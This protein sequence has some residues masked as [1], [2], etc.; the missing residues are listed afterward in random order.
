[1]HVEPAQRMRRVLTRTPDVLGLGRVPDR[2]LQVDFKLGISLE[3]ALV[4]VGDV[5]I[6]DVQPRWSRAPGVHG[7]TAAAATSSTSTAAVDL[8][9]VVAGFFYLHEADLESSSALIRAARSAL[10]DADR[11]SSLVTGVLPQV[12]VERPREVRLQGDDRKS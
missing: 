1:V 6:R 3:E 5:E 8:R 9:R 4:I 7:A 12:R 10:V 2:G 11:P